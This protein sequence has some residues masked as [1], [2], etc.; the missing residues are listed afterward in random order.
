M[1]DYLILGGGLA[2]CVLATRLK[3]YNPWANVT[4]VEAGPDEHGH[5]WI[6]E[7]MGTFNL[8]LS[9]F[10]YNYLTVPQTY[11]DG[12][13]VYNAGG[14]LLSGSSAVNYAMWTRG[15]KAD[16]GML[17]PGRMRKTQVC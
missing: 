2:G 5:E 4:L 8:H 15:G 16:Y 13:Q 1:C 3:E 7:P 6:T 14:K 10:E 9:N 11:Y 17:S 12:R